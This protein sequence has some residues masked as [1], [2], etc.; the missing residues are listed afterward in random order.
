MLSLSLIAFAP[1]A[2][3]LVWACDWSG[4]L[5]NVNTSDAS[6]GLIGSTGLADLGALEFGPD[7]NLY[8]FTSGSSASLYRIDPNTAAPTLIGSLGLSFVIEGAL[9]FSSGGTAYGAHSYPSLLNLF[10]VDV[11]TGVATE[12][13]PIGTTLH[14]SNGLAWRSDGMLVSVDPQDDGLEAIDP[15]TGAVT[16]IATLPFSPG[17]V[18]G[19][20]TDYST[21]LSYLGTGMDAIFPGTNS[22]YTFDLYT[23]ATNLIGEFSGFANP[24]EIYGVSGL[25][26]STVPEPTT[27]L[28]LGMGLTGLAA[29][30]KRRSR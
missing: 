9:T 28:L 18:S 16:N 11:N 15:I 10:T 8:G 19:M 26:A 27:L 13:P 20:T 14:E 24:G 7:G 5:Y 6:L 29:Y 22:L 3:A 2:K 21:S 4:N 1:S 17:A 25:A 30:R 23:G 12:G